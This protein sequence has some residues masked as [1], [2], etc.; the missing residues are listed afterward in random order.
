MKG[1]IFTTP[2]LV[3]DD[4]ARTDWNFEGVVPRPGARRRPTGARRR[5]SRRWRR[6]STPRPTGGDAVHLRRGGA[7]RDRGRRA[8]AHR[9]GAGRVGG[10]G[11]GR[12][13][14]RGGP[15][16]RPVE[17]VVTSRGRRAAGGRDCD[18]AT[19]WPSTSPGP[20]QPGPARRRWVPWWSRV[21]AVVAVPDGRGAGW[22][23]RRRGSSV[24]LSGAGRRGRSCSPWSRP[25]AALPGA[26]GVRSRRRAGAVEP[27]C[28]RM[29]TVAAALPPAAAQ[30][31]R[32]ALF[33]RGPRSLPARSTLLVGVVAVAAALAA[34]TLR[35]EP[36]RAWST[37]PARYGAG[38]GSPRRRRVR[39]RSPCSRSSRS[40]R[41]HPA[42][43]GI[44]V[45]DYGDVEVEG[46]HGARP[47]ASPAWPARCP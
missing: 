28:R 32:F 46:Q 31:T 41:D 12:R 10:R 42:V 36:H 7:D 8:A 19:G 26:G 11:R 23:S 6:G 22:P 34:A 18:R 2:A 20:S 27:C 29:A 33:D 25:L 14:D 44:A 9:R 35:G 1:R 5:R 13:A 43:A 47:S 24:D 4:G 39:S 16:D 30:G 21:I 3:G 38:V 40:S 45:G 15:G 17:P 37:T